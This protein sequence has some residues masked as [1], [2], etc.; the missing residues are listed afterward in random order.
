MRGIEGN[1]NGSDDN[2][3]MEYVE[4]DQFLKKPELYCECVTEGLNLRPG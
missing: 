2:E 4:D 3:E 1:L